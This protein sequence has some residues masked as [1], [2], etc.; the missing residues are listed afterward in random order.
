MLSGRPPYGAGVRRRLVLLVLLLGLAVAAGGWIRPSVHAG[1]TGQAGSCGTRKGAHPRVYRHV[2]W[3]LF[4]NDSY[5]DVIGSSSAPYLNG[6]ARR[7]G[8]A[9]N[10]SAITH[11]SLP[12]Y[13]ALTSGST[14]GISD[15]GGP[16]EH[17]LSGPSIFSQ[18][19]AGWRAVAE[20]MPSPCAHDDAGEYLARHNPAVYYASVAAAC[21][22]QD[23]AGPLRVSA[24]FTF[25]TPNRC[26][27][28][29]D[30]PLA[31]VDRWLSHALPPLLASPAYRQGGTAIFL[32]WD[33][34]GH[35]SNQ[36]PV[37]VVSPYTRAGTRSGAAFDHYSLLGTTESMLGVRCLAAA[38]HAASM[39]RA[40]GL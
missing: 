22:T 26:N 2:V 32:T 17:T 30:C 35:E 20:S 29:H 24:R 21:R 36:V 8:L 10:Y 25:V 34:G 7:C 27:D 11:P 39:R 31:S 38:C 33:E 5:K 40:F 1:A 19:G 3:I 23:A 14:H 16:D 28:G 6:L 15:D 12:N 18:L 13:I 4:E 37:I 9:T